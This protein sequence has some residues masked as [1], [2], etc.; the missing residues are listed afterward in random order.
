MQLQ[1]L[2]FM[3]LPFLPA[4]NLF[5][6]VGFVVAERVLYMPSMGFCLLVGYGF[7]LLSER[8]SRKAIW[9][10]LAVF[11]F[12]HSVK[13]WERNFDWESEYSIFMSGLKVNRKNAKVLALFSQLEA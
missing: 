11:L 10:C 3:V 1:G 12:A 8:V 7:H 5:F 4:S 13:T 2:A 6:P 9:C